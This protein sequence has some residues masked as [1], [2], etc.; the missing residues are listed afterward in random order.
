MYML[1]FM[2]L[3]DIYVMQAILLYKQVRHIVYYII[4]SRKQ[5]ELDKKIKRLRNLNIVEL[6]Y[7]EEP[8][9]ET[10]NAVFTDHY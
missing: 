7:V 2:S 4:I 9:F 3:C 5:L 6:F 8:K 10:V 1:H